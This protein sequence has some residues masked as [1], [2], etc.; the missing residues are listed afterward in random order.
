MS[1]EAIYPFPLVTHAIFL[2]SPV[3]IAGTPHSR[4]EK[5]VFTRSLS[6]IFIRKE[7]KRYVVREKAV[8]MEIAS[9][10]LLATGK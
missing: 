6:R 8:G 10:L 5:G 2:L 1:A 3:D 7:Q 9:R 4:L